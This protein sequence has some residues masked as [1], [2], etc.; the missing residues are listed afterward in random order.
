MFKTESCMRT[1]MDTRGNK[2][3]SN[4]LRIF[5]TE[6]QLCQI[7]MG[8]FWLCWQTLQCVRCRRNRVTEMVWAL[9]L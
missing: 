7:Y 2:P 5:Q 9:R 3:W 8:G 1:D 4:S 6:S